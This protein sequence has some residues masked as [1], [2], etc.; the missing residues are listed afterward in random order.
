MSFFVSF[1]QIPRAAEPCCDFDY[2]DLSSDESDDDEEKKR[3][4]G[5][6]KETT[7]YG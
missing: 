1:L 4:N 2:A 6:L 5:S 3:I 7:K